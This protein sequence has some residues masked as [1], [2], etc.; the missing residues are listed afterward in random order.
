[1]YHLYSVYH[2]H[3]F[4]RAATKCHRLCDLKLWKLL[5][6]LEAKG[7]GWRCWQSWCPQRSLPL[8]YWGPPPLCLHRPLSSVFITSV[9]HLSSY[10]DTS[11]T[12]LAPTQHLNIHLITSLRA[13][14]PSNTHFLR[15]WALGF[16]HI[17]FTG[18]NA[19]HNSIL[20]SSDLQKKRGTVHI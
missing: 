17:S 9:Q 14:C 8:V 2:L 11:H 13:L 19:T 6:F 4:S 7:P 18:H 1:M 12:G 15:S 10:K 16:Q 20:H 5:T 3:L